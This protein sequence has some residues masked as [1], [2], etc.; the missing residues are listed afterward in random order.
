V[1]KPAAASRRTVLI[2]DDHDLFAE[3]LQAF[4]S[5]EE[6][7]AVVGRAA[8][9]EE[10]ARLCAELRPDIVLMDISMP[11]LNGFEAARRIR[12]ETP[13]TRVLFLTGSASPADVAEAR[14]AGGA[15]YVTKDKLA[16]ELL[17]AI[18]ATPPRA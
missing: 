7:V 1:E 4:L 3:S 2:A 16:T 18:V 6:W 12:D 14:A 10:A 17:D 9:G 11:V 13:E 15:G 5:T 8:N